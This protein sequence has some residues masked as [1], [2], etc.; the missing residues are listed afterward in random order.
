MV[1]LGCIELSAPQL[2][3]KKMEGQIVIIN[4]ESK[5]L[6]MELEEMFRHARQKLNWPEK[7]ADLAFGINKT[8][9]NFVLG[10][11]YTLLIRF[12]HDSNYEYWIRSETLKDFINSE[13]CLSFVSKTVKLYNIPLSLFRSKP[14]FSGGR[15]DER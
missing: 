3:Y 14:N 4:T 9:M 13:N 8:I 10:A 6:I 5:V 1:W 15:N 11:E 12:S 7:Y 2:I